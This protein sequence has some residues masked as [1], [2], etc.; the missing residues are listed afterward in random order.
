VTGSQEMAM[1]DLQAV[2]LALLIVYLFARG[3]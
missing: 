2:L 3:K 1:T